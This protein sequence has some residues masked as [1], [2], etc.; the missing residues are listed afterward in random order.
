[1]IQLHNSL[2]GKKETLK[3]IEPEKVRMY[4]CGPTVYNY[5]HIGNLRSFVFADIFRRVFEYN[6]YEVKQVMSV[7]DVGHLTDDG[8]DGEDKVE[9]KAR[10]NKKKASEITSHFTKA[11]FKDIESLNINTE[12]IIF[13]KA[14][15]HIKEQIDLIKKI[16]TKN[17]T[18]KTSDG[19]YFNTSRIQNCDIFRA[20]GD[21]LR[22]GARIE[23]NSEKHCPTDFALW[24]FSKPYEKRQQE[25]ESPWGVGFPGW[26]LECSAIA[27]KHLGEQLD[28]HTGGIDHKFPHH[29]NE[30][31]Q[32]ECATGKSPFSRYW[33]HNGFLSLNGSKMS[34]SEGNFLT[35]KEIKEKGFPPESFRFWLLGTHYRNPANFT[36]QGLRGAHNANEKILEQIQTAYLKSKPKTSPDK[37]YIEEF[38]QNI[39][40]DFDTPSSL[41]L[42]WKLL[43]DKEIED[44]TKIATVNSFD[45]VLGLNLLSAVNEYSQIPSEIKDLTKQREKARANK[46]WKKS[47]ILRDKIKKKGYIVKDSLDGITLKKSNN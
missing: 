28:V 3:T 47:D 26:H 6:G 36:W 18:Y 27:I 5:T 42:L 39:N 31:I 45:R 43:K 15:E 38:K 9:K 17:Y 2:S 7:T 4:N 20:V 22:E 10:Q 11:F 34:K 25:W 16:E 44:S 33:L 32:S 40:N 41:A 24:K 21:N 19:I 35:L 8:D 1:M 46:E 12:K 37:K 30:I 29:P 23:I 14:S 13:S